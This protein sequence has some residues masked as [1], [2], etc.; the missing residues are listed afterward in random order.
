MT[1]LS[2]DRIDELIEAINAEL[3]RL[4]GD[5]L[6]STC[7]SLCVDRRSKEWNRQQWA[8]YLYVIWWQHGKQF[9]LSTS[10]D[11]AD[12]LDAIRREIFGP[13][14]SEIAKQSTKE[15]CDLFS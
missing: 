12:V 10:V 5:T 11:V 14:F 1:E 3:L 6:G 4:L 2:A 7:V 9:S 15:F 8:S 13:P